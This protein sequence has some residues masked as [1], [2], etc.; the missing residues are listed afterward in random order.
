MCIHLNLIFHVLHTDSIA[1]NY[2]AGAL[3]EDSTCQYING[4][5]DPIALN[6]N[7]SATMD[8]GSCTY[9]YGCTD[10]TAYN[11]NYNA[12]MDDGSC[13]YTIPFGESIGQKIVIEY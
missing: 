3:I 6:Y 7:P 13:C 10:F 9:I 5:T 4:C 11:F 1:L 12:T 2:D 8:D